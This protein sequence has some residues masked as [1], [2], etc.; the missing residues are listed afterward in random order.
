MFMNI[1]GL[2]FFLSWVLVWISY[3]GIGLVLTLTIFGSYN[4]TPPSPVAHMKPKVRV[5]M[6]HM[7]HKR[8]VAHED[9]VLQMEMEIG[10]SIRGKRF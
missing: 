2:S 9:S 7:D 8:D 6:E 3:V 5:N 10:L 4:E 1:C